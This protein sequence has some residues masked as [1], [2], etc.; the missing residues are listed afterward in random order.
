GAAAF[1]ITNATPGQTGSKCILVTSTSTD[2]GVVKLYLARLGAD[3][4]ENNITV[5]TEIGT[6]GTFNSCAGFVA[7]A[8][9]LPAESL[10]TVAAEHS[11][12]SSGVLPWTT[13]GTP[14]ES[15]SYRVTWVFDTTGL[16]QTQVDAL[17]GKSASADVVWELQTS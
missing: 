12:Y 17:Q 2:A 8:P 3:G 13:T 16:T 11:A 1:Q 5:S 10:A 9:A 7:E 15:K 4:L 14:G 6:G